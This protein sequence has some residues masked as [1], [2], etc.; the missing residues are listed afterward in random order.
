M[1]DCYHTLR[2]LGL[3]YDTPAVPG[4]FLYQAQPHGATTVVDGV[5]MAGG[6]DAKFA[7]VVDQIQSS[8]W[9]HLW[10][11]LE[12]PRED[13]KPARRTVA[14]APVV[15][16]ARELPQVD[17]P[18][19]FLGSP[20]YEITLSTPIGPLIDVEREEDAEQGLHWFVSQVFLP[21]FISREATFGKADF[22][23]SG[24]RE[25]TPRHLERLV[26]PDF[27][28]LNV[29][30]VAFVR[31]YGIEPFQNPKINPVELQK[32]WLMRTPEGALLFRAKVE[33]DRWNGSE[34]PTIDFYDWDGRFRIIE[35]LEPKRKKGAP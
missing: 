27:Y 7:V 26:I 15:V 9:P 22:D 34:N 2:E 19:R 30:G 10:M 28:F 25:I 18:A 21:F 33:A 35:K 1:A 23:P 6:A 3:K 29:L 4:K 16:A 31:K 5:D 12:V 11:E 32:R 20:F 24:A 14:H 8:Y 13:A 17:T